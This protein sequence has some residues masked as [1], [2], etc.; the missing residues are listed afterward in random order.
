MKIA[1]VTDSGTGH[2]VEYWKERG[3]YS[4]PLQLEAE[5]KSYEEG[6]EI[7]YKD[8]IKDLHENKPI[9]TSLPK[10]GQIED[11]FETLK[12][13]GYDTI[14]AVPICKGISSTMNAMEMAANTH[15]L[16]FIGIDCYTTA[17]V[18]G[19]MIEVAKRMWDQGRSLETIIKEMER[20]AASCDTI[21][22]VDDL[23]HLKQGGRLTP[24][25]AALGGLLKIKPILHLDLET[26]GRIDVLGKV[27]TMSKAQDYVIE[28]L[29]KNGV[30]KD[31]TI[32]VAHVDAREA[33]QKFGERIQ[34]AIEGAKIEYIDLVSAVSSHT[35][36]GTLAVQAFKPYVAI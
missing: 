3:I 2:T 34:K 1:F 11:L 23:N 36:L 17:V 26:D 29:K 4:L 22:L 25:A 30:N 20:I 8:V 32:I 28:R 15:E 35:G 9:K 14:F 19:H 7:T 24:M 21:L 10:L 33:A 12:E 6:E 18:Q 5:G 13:E 27:R 16:D 31:Y